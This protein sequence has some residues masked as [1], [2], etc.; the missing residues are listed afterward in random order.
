MWIDAH[1]HLDHYGDA[2]DAALDA[3]ERH[4]IVT[5]SVSMDP[6]SYRA[7]KAIAGRSALVLA[8]FGVHP[9]EAHKL[10]G[11]LGALDEA[12]AESPMLGEIGLD[13]H[14]VRDAD[15]Y[16]AQRRVFAYFLAAARDQD[17][18]VNLHT[19]GAEREVLDQLQRHDIR[20][21][22][23]HWYSGPRDVLDDLI[24]FGA[25]FT[26]G[27]E[28]MRSK[29]IQAIA[30][31]IPA[32]R[33]LTETDNPGGWEWFTGKIGMPELLLD[34]AQTLARVRGMTVEALRETVRANFLRLAGDDPRLEA[35]C[36]PLQ[37]T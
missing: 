3:I 2:L 19:K 6:D 25:Y 15:S 26:V 11:D 8:T 12:I 28:V 17:K 1:A 29:H 7:A 32:D 35:L 27:V 18:I 13:F 30:R 21:A 4:R 31:H 34:T 37:R 5:I 9:W 10:S 23:V 33:L 36:A 22:I 14:W 20:R 16:S 24:A